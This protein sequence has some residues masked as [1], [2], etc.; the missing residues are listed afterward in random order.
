MSSLEKAK[1][2]RKRISILRYIPFVR[3]AVLS[4]SHVTGKANDDSHIDLIIGVEDG[5]VW[6][7]RALTLFFLDILGI[8]N[9]PPLPEGDKLCLSHFMSVADL[10]MNDPENSYEEESYKRLLPVYGDQSACETFFKANIH[11]IKDIPDYEK[12]PF[13]TGKKRSL[14]ATIFEKMLS[15]KLGDFLET[16]AREWQTGKI[17]RYMAE[18]KMAERKTRVICRND[19]VETYYDIF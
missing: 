5:R 13:Y 14:M 12:S 4:G 9:K 19:R 3:L 6:L 8:R 10:K 15:G 18:I 16:Q 1:K 2:I 7:S 17:N 11:I